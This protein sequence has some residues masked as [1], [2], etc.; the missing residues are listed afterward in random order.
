MIASVASDLVAG[1]AHSNFSP[2][3]MITI[4]EMESRDCYD[5]HDLHLA[6]P[7]RG[8]PGYYHYKEVAVLMYMYVYVYLLYVVCIIHMYSFDVH[9]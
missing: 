6:S 9:M 4:K 1:M 3:F 7:H 8:T 5:T 2:S